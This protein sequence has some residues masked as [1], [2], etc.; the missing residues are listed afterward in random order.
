MIH[1][2]LIRSSLGRIIFLYCLVWPVLALGCLVVMA[3]I[4]GIFSLDIFACLTWGKC[5]IG[6]IF[7]KITR[8]NNGL[9]CRVAKNRNGKTSI[10]RPIY[11]AM[12]R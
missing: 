7:I 4:S 3:E 10:A 2:F 8:V 11:D 6:R 9:T 1:F 5:L 12:F